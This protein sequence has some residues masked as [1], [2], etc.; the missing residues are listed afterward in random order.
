VTGSEPRSPAPAEPV[1]ARPA[2]LPPEL[3]REV[4]RLV[5]ETLGDGVA[6]HLAAQDWPRLPVLVRRRRV[7]E[8]IETASRCPFCQAGGHD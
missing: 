3:A 5:W 8:A 7:V 6:G 1:E 2:P 4:A